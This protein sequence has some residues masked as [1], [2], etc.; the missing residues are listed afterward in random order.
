V[1]KNEEKKPPHH[2]VGTVPKSNGKIVDTEVKLI[3]LILWT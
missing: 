3:P 1:Q 2:I